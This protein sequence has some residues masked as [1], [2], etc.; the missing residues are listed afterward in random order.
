MEDSLG[1]LKKNGFY[2]D[3][4]WGDTGGFWAERNMICHMFQKDHS[5]C[6]VENWLYRVRSRNGESSW[7]AFAVIHGRDDGGS[8]QGSGCG[9]V[10][11]LWDS[12]HT[13]KVESVNSPDGLDVA[14]E[15]KNS[16]EWVQGFGL[17]SQ[18]D[19]I[20]TTFTGV[21]CRWS[22]FW[23]GRSGV[24]VWRYWIFWVVRNVRCI[25]V[26]HYIYVLVFRREM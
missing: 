26:S 25:W 18:K 5:D 8:D 2:S 1:L 19:G 10:G 3:Y 15:R 22:Q 13:L 20:D 4:H 12:G 6:C 11:E 16:Q 24:L 17:S 7:E 14:C 23:G 21:G 9:G